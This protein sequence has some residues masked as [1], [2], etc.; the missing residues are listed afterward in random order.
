MVFKNFTVR[1]TSI[2]A[3]PGNML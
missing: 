3:I 2:Y 1:L